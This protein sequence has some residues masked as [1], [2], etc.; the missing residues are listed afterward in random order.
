M[1]AIALGSGLNSAFRGGKPSVWNRSA[2]SPGPTFTMLVAI[3]FSFGIAY[4]GVRGVK[5]ATA[6][7]IAVNADPDRRVACILGDDVGLSDE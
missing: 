7:N 4:I 5:A 3:V 6:V 1:S 2:S